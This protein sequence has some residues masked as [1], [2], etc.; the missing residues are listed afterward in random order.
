MTRSG[1]IAIFVVKIAITAGL[2]WFALR[3]L[4][5]SEVVA[6]MASANWGFAALAIL[7]LAAQPAIGALRWF[8]VMR[9]MGAGIS[10]SQSVR[11][12]YISTLLNQILPGGVGGDAVRMWLA[13]REGYQISQA[14]NGV[15][16]DRIL[17]LA[18]LLAG[19][20]VCVVALDRYEELKALERALVPLALLAIAGLGV[21]MALDRSPAALQRF[22][23][24]RALGY[25]AKDARRLFLSASAMPAVLA[26]ALL[27]HIN[28][29]SSLFLFAL[30]F[31]V[32][33]GAWLLAAAVPPVILASSI[34]V[35]VGGWGTRETAMVALMGALSA[36]AESAVV[37]SIAFGI[38]GILI[39]LPGAFF[40]SGSL[41]KPAAAGAESR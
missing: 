30:A 22:R 7:V 33:L 9:H 37:A 24:V 8:V 12:T 16:L 14:L 31:N 6:Q 29:C 40:I 35:S 34:P 17:G 23:S 1:R 15:A 11:L 20:S 4:E 28:L 2:L 25:L 27:G 39:S 18:T 21:L 3:N 41:R 13:F 32:P 38:S 36:P 10:L 26:L 5:F 19:A